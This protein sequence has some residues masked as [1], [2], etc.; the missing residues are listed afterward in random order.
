[1]P[2]DDLDPRLHRLFNLRRLF[3]GIGAAE[4]DA[5]GLERDRLGHRR[6]A[7][8]NRSLPVENAEVPTDR[9]GR[10]RRAVA[11]ALRTAIP[12]IS[13][14]VDDE[15]FP[16]AFGPVVGPSHFVTGAVAWA[17]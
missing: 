3:D 9:L 15:L 13:R 4:N 6:G 14:H 2:A 16:C 8:G 1:M 5:V 17:M 11:D 7:P 12:L 10:L